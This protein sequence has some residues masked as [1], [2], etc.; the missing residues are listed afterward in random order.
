MAQYST[1][2]QTWTSQYGNPSSIVSTYNAQE[3]HKDRRWSGTS[4]DHFRN[5]VGSNAYDGDHGSHFQSSG[6]LE[7]CS[8]DAMI[9]THVDLRN[10]EM[11]DFLL[12]KSVGTNKWKR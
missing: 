9:R 6:G 3:R 11:M 12:Q 4:A 5:K 8:E 2:M 7:S 10:G 1:A